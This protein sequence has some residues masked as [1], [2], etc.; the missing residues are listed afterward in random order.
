M[1]I[2][3]ASNLHTGHEGREVECAPAQE[4]VEVFHEPLLDLLGLLPGLVLLHLPQDARE[5]AAEQ[6][7]GQDGISLPHNRGHRMVSQ[8][9]GLEAL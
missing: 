2:S 5:Q 8:R 6:L 7:L 4:G 9:F 3:G 1:Q